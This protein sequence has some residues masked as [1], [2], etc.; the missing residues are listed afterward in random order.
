MACDCIKNSHIEECDGKDL[1]TAIDITS[2]G[3]RPKTGKCTGTNCCMYFTI[4]GKW[5]L[6]L[7]T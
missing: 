7:I 2:Q 5:C 1:C 4:E 3:R 6:L